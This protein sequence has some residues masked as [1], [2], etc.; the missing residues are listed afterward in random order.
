MY[1]FFRLWAYAILLPVCAG[2]YLA[3]DCAK[4][5]GWERAIPGISLVVLALPVV[6]W[7]IGRAKRHNLRVA[8]PWLALVPGI[9]VSLLPA[10]VRLVGPWQDAMTQTRDVPGTLAIIAI[11][12]L[13]VIPYVGAAWFGRWWFR[14]QYHRSIA[15]DAP[16]G[17]W[18]S[19]G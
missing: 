7:S 17:D 13:V 6:Y 15:L 1:L 18:Q 10:M 5:W 9:L 8:M 11:H 14:R 3:Y 19:L 2:A 16:V 12:T 4:A